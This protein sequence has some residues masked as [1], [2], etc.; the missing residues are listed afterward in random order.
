M[1]DAIP[2]SPCFEDTPLLFG[3]NLIGDIALLAENI[4]FLMGTPNVIP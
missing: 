3:H 4:S 1:I 2:V